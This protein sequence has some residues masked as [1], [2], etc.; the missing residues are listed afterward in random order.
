MENYFTQVVLGFL[1][2]K[3]GSYFGLSDVSLASGPRSTEGPQYVTGGRIAIMA[4]QPSTQNQRL[5]ST[6]RQ[7]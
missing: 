4:V 5:A 2:G 7:R 6:P 1:T 3:C